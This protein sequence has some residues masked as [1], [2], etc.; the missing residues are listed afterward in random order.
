MESAG[1][2]GRELKYFYQLLSTDWERGTPPKI[3]V[4][5]QNKPIVN[6]MKFR[7]ASWYLIQPW[8]QFHFESTCNLRH[9]CCFCGKGFK[10]EAPA[11]K[12]VSVNVPQRL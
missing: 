4:R 2:T 1:Q 10:A 5:G 7:F 9:P 3:T 8:S 12:I 6:V 11:S